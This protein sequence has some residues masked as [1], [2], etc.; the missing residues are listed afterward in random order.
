M[1]RLRWVLYGL[2]FSTLT[3]GAWIAGL[4][5]EMYE[6]SQSLALLSV[7]WI[8]RIMVRLFLQPL[9]GS[10]IDRSERSRAVWMAY[11]FSG[12]FG[13]LCALWINWKGASVL[14]LLVVVTGF[15]VFESVSSPGLQKLIQIALPKQALNRFNGRRLAI[16]RSAAIVGPA[17]GAELLAKTG[18]IVPLIALF[19]LAQIFLGW[20]SLRSRVV[21]PRVS[22]QHP[23]LYAVL[24]DGW[25]YAGTR[26]DLVAI[27]VL[28][29][30]ASGGWRMIEILVPAL[31]HA[32]VFGTGLT[33]PAYSMSAVGSIGMGWIL[34]RYQRDYPIRW[35]LLSQLVNM[36]PFALFVLTPTPLGII[37]AV[38]VTGMN[39]DF[40]DVVVSTYLQKTV[41]HE[42]YGR[43]SSSYR[44]ILAMGALPVV[45]ATWL[46]IIPTIAV[47]SYVSLVLLGLGGIVIWRMLRSADASYSFTISK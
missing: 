22:T 29:A 7:I 24:K 31:S 23:T 12:W 38:L 2:G 4:S 8:I 43:T 16:S 46:H 30:T 21:G 11:L 6:L 28:A 44:T 42:F 45:V 15:Q 5:I 47:A 27:F 36:I 17:L 35:I 10:I 41:P 39:A 1:R 13:I 9:A 33:G 40:H 3:S 19:A 32:T 34:S 20:G 14:T 25:H 37:M 18:S 26:K